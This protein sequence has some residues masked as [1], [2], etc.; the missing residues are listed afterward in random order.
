[1]PCRNAG[2]YSRLTLAA[3]L[4]IFSIAPLA[5]Q[6]D[7]AAPTAPSDKIGLSLLAG[8]EHDFSAGLKDGPTGNLATNRYDAKLKFAQDWDA[9]HL[10]FG[11]TYSYINY[12]FSGVANLAPFT[13]VQGF[14]MNLYYACD[15][16]DGWGAFG[17]LE[18]GF[19]AETAATLTRGEEFVGALGGTYKFNDSLSLFA[20]PMYYT[21]LEE[22]ASLTLFG[23]VK[24]NVTPQWMLSA[25]AGIDNGGTVAYDV[26]GNLHT[27]VDLTADYTSYWF[28]TTPIPAGT[29][30]VNERQATVS[31][32]V[33]QQ[34]GGGFYIRPYVGGVFLRHYQYL[35]NGHAANN[36]EVGAGALIGLQV[37]ASF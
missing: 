26:F 12:D 17:L 19:F 1:M 24:W 32:G 34:L 27:V 8:Y 22:N 30:A 7:S 4:A 16:A 35:V 15:I 20:G 2:F 33:T 31:L 29:Q 37:G 36:F 25:F 28:R 13:N 11:A 10:S 18:G 3:I 14:D 23:G 21:R 9:N 6:T 5:A